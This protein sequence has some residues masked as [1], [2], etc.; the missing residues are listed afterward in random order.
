V[1]PEKFYAAGKQLGSLV[2][3]FVVGFAFSFPVSFGWRT[4]RLQAKHR[5]KE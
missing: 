1:L 2:A 4:I 3:Q 5:R